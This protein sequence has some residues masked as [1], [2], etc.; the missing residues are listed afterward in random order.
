MSAVIIKSCNNYRVEDLID[1]INS[2]IDLLGGWGK[3][4]RPQ[5]TVLL[6]VNLIGPKTPDTAAVTHPEFVRAITRILMERKCKVWIGDSSGGAIAGISPTGRSFIVS[7]LERVAIEEGAKIK[8]FDK[9]GVMGIDTSVGKMYLA[10]PLFEADFIINLPKLKT[11]SAGIYTGAVKN[12]FGCIPGLRK[13]AYHKGAPNPKEFGTVLA[14]IYESVNV[15]LHIMDGITAMQGEGPTAGTV[16]H[17][18]KILLS[19]DPLALDAVAS[20]MIGINIEDNPIFDAA[21]ERK[22]G[23]WK[24]QNIEVEGDY[25]TPPKLPNFKLPR[26]FKLR[27]KVNYGLMVTL[28]DLLKARPKIDENHCTNCNMCVESCPVYAIDKMTKIINYDKCIECMCCHEL[29]MYNAVKL[30]R[31]KF[32]GKVVSK[33]LKI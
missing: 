27:K 10:K 22:L 32:I 3:F 16:Y 8:N 15:G 30:K 33:L 4:I 25:L 6:K 13:A 7:G 9:E 1:I 29:C 2:G 12:L 26:A 18:E 21:R 31:E 20:K 19:T 5:M 14:A 24:S 28:I 11:H 23:E 17:A